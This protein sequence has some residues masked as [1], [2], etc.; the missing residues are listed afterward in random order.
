MERTMPNRTPGPTPAGWSEDPYEQGMPRL[1]DGTQWTEQRRAGRR[2]HLA[3][4]AEP[5]TG[6]RDAA[7]ALVPF[8]NLFPQ[9]R[10]AWP[11]AYLP[12]RDWEPRADEGASSLS[13][14]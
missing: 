14:S 4:F 5:P 3:E 1:H 2:P 9:C 13:V 6:G 10:I 8:Y 12:Y 11:L 7:F